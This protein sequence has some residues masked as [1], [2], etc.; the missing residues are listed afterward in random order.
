MKVQLQK[1][2]V[3]MQIL[4]GMLMGAFLTLMAMTYIIARVQT[5]KAEEE[6]R[7]RNKNVQI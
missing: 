6:K 4:M 1:R 2:G 5:V 7:E 3:K